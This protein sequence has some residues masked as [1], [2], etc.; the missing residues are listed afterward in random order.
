MMLF[1]ALRQNKKGQTLTLGPRLPWRG[2]LYSSGEP[3]LPAD[4]CV[5]F[6]KK[7]GQVTGKVCG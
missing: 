1:S 6:E 7:Q 5:A 4:F 2:T 3:A